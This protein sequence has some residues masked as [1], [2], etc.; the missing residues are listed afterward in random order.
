[1]K[2]LTHNMLTSRAIKGVTVG[3][4]LRIIVSYVMLVIIFL[5]NYNS[6][7]QSFNLRYLRYLLIIENKRKYNSNDRKKIKDY[8][9]NILNNL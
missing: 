6:R 1:M 5:K 3:Y 8:F 7:L 2:L 9:I 4:P